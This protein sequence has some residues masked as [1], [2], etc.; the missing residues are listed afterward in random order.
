MALVCPLREDITK[1]KGLKHNP[2][3]IEDDEFYLNAAKPSQISTS[4]QFQGGNELLTSSPIGYTSILKPPHLE[5]SL[6]YIIHEAIRH[7]VIPL[8]GTHLNHIE[9]HQSRKH[10]IHTKAQQLDIPLAEME[11]HICTCQELKRLRIRIIRDILSFFFHGFV[12]A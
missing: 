3:Q 12:A 10:L 6:T 11:V 9:L 8:C 5:D 1:T 7:V 2:T 4:P